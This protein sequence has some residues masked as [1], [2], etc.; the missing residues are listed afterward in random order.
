MFRFT[1]HDVLRMLPFFGLE[2]LRFRHRYEATSL[3]AL[4]LVLIRLAYPVRLLSL[5]DIFGRSRSWLSTIFNDTIMH[6]HTRW[7]PKLHWNSEW[8][9]LE[10]LWRYRDAINGAGC[11]DCYWGY[12]DGT[13]RR[14]CRPEE[15][16]R[17]Y[18]SGHKRIHCWKGQSIVTPD[19]LIASFA[20][21]YVGKRADMWLVR[22]SG[23]EAKLR[24]VLLPISNWQSTNI[25]F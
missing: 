11:G 6:L 20:G 24:E 15:D 12:I 22:E 14:I 17:N 8:L 5:C 3:E 7:A 9:T 2:T 19:G 18:Y 13:A 25:Y 4:C 1:K 23:I 21:P 10:R 16:Q